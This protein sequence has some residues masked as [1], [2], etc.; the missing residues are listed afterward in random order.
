M[1]MVRRKRET[2]YIRRAVAA[3]LSAAMLCSLCACSKPI[4]V[5]TYRGTVENVSGT[6]TSLL[7]SVGE[8]NQLQMVASSGL[9]ELLFDE[10]T[11]SVCVRDTSRG[12]D[13]KLW[14]SLPSQEN[15]D[16]AVATLEVLSG[17]KLYTLNT[18]DNSVSFRNAQC[19][20]SSDGL[21]VT[22]VLTPDVV[23]AQ[24]TSYDKDDI[25]FKLIVT[26]QLKDG[27]MYVSAEYENLVT[28][29]E[30]KLTK[31]SFLNA[32]GAYTEP[33]QGDYIFVPDGS[34]A[35]IKTDTRD[36]SFDSA[37]S[38]AVYG[39]DAAS[40][41][42]GSTSALVPAYGMKQGN[43]AFVVIID[44]GDALA[45]I[46]ADRVRGDNDFYEVG[47]T[48][49]VTPYY[50]S[51]K[52]YYLSSE[53][54]DEDLSLCIR[55]LDGSNANYTGMA[56]AAREQLIRERTLST[57]TAEEQE[58]LPLDLTVI[59]AGEDTLFSIKDRIKPTITKTFTDF[60]Q[61]QDMLMRMKAKGIDSIKLRYKSALS[62]GLDQSNILRASLLSRLGSRSDLKE[63]SEYVKAQNMEMYLDVDILSASKSSAFSSGKSAENIAG[64]KAEYE[65]G[66]ELSDS[67]GKKSYSKRLIGIDSVD[68]AIVSL[69]SDTR[70]SQFTGFCLNDVGSL[71][72]SDYKHG[73]NRQESAK[74]ISEELPSLTANMKLMID[75]GNFCMIKDVSFISHLPTSASQ[76]RAAYSS[77]PFLQLILHGIV[78][79]SCTP[80]NLSSDS[81]TAFLRCIEYGACPA[82]EWSYTS[83]YNDKKSG[84]SAD[85]DDE[86]A[87]VGTGIYY[88]NW[89]ASAAEIY[90]QADDT[91][92]DLQSSRMTSHSEVVTGVFCT[93]YDTGT[94]I[95]V[96]YTD[97]D[98]TV[99][100]ITIQAG[101]YL[102]IN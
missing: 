15:I 83:S 17:D 86:D 39:D 27:S 99:S 49:N 7:H 1:I 28:D 19:N 84:K 12:D 25:A 32:F 40:G 66:N 102:R 10:T 90:E 45:T 71:L 69:L 51:D 65:C 20:F 24:K 8:K 93:E 34:G 56:A 95:Y 96:N 22:Y 77:I 36:D 100:G 41:Q 13:G 16:S 50:I 79:Y 73:F 85:S 2:K 54:Y 26:Y 55:F 88:E 63:L 75:T 57:K 74:Q 82:Y 81:K 31:L 94:K 78:G 60:E 58:Y 72:Y 62:G 42:S 101:D 76:E 80:L 52:K 30:A 53:S 61:A 92:H 70:F 44:G 6:E 29:S 43:N 14:S 18:Q 98:V 3:V 91:L 89:I 59:G 68:D 37:V 67:L 23:T 38:F 9:I 33:E 11:Y 48:F 21:T 35:I 87:S 4:K 47:A 97:S 46:T 5:T 64:K